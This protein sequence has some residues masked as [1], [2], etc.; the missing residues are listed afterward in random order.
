MISRLADAH[1]VKAWE[2]TFISVLLL[3][4]AIALVIMLYQGAEDEDDGPPLV[5][6]QTRVAY[7]GEVHRGYTLSFD[8][9]AITPKDRRIPWREV[10]VRLVLD[11][12][13]QPIDLG[14]VKHY[15]DTPTFDTN[16]WYVKGGNSM[17]AVEV[18]DII[19]VTGLLFAP[20]GTIE[21]WR[22]GDQE[23][24][25]SIPGSPVL[26]AMGVE[27][28]SIRELD[29][30]ILYNLTMMLDKLVSDGHLYGVRHVS[31]RLVT[32]DGDRPW[33]DLDRGDIGVTDT[34]SIEFHYRCSELYYHPI[35]MSPSSCISSGDII[36]VNNLPAQCLGGWLYL[37]YDDAT[38]ASFPIP[39][40]LPA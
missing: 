33:P 35:T 1:Y 5:T 30:V 39:E 24:L 15:T 3:A 12:E 34:T 38:M 40:E 11:N 37:L 16:A 26:V 4:M 23:L 29:N 18:N 17:K 31:L 19:L 36:I 20:E 10:S 13:V 22:G 27:N 7:N 14:K 9:A 8:V 6:S 25:A 32:G 28:V 21:I 2:L